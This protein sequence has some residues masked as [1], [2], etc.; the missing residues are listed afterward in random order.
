[1]TC[2]AS[3][4]AD[5]REHLLEQ[6]GNSDVSTDIACYVNT[7]KRAV[8]FLLIQMACRQAQSIAI[9]PPFGDDIVTD[10]TCRCIRLQ[11]LLDALQTCIYAHTWDAAPEKLQSV[12]IAFGLTN[13][14]MLQCCTLACRA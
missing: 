3:H 11:N 14:S 8:L 2:I 9:D 7:L 12:I 4:I 13:F 10:W 5:D 6:M 1:M